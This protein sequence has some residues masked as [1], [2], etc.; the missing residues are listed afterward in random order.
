MRSQAWRGVVG[1]AR[2]NWK[3]DLGNETEQ[4]R[5]IEEKE[6]SDAHWA[7]LGSGRPT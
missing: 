4:L 2:K 7:V 3:C 6:T 5:R 1:R